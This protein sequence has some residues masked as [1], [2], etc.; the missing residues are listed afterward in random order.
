MICNLFSGYFCS[1]KT[2]VRELLSSSIS[3]KALI[4]SRSGHRHLLLVFLQIV[5]SSSARSS[6][7]RKPT[8]A[9]E[10][11]EQTIHKTPESSGEKKRV[12]V[13]HLLSSPYIY[14]FLSGHT[15][16]FRV[17]CSH[18]TSVNY[19]NA[20]KIICLQTAMFIFILL[21]SFGK[22]SYISEFI[23]ST[24]KGVAKRI[25]RLSIRIRWHFP[26]DTRRLRQNNGFVDGLRLSSLVKKPSMESRSSLL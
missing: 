19:F 21:E 15:I 1:G 18:L 24:L 23:E 7:E 12:F 9:I 11:R 22:A 13:F 2:L 17:Y 4:K 8:K 14:Y 25:G 20:D 6:A 5:F 10:K 16:D 3:S 26:C